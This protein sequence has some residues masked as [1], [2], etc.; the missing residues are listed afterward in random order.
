MSFVFAVIVVLTQGVTMKP[1][2]EWNSGFLC[3]SQELQLWMY[4]V[5][6]D[7]AVAFHFV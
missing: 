7:E 1:I 5:E 3:H 2:L 6:L 4:T